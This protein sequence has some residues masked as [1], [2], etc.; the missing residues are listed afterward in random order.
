LSD[1]ASC[2]PPGN[3][4]SARAC[5]P[6]PP[7]RPRLPVW[8]G[9]VGWPEWTRSAS[10][11]QRPQKR[12]KSP[13]HNLTRRARKQGYGPTTDATHQ[14]K[15]CRHTAARHQWPQERR[16]PRAHEIT[17]QKTKRRTRPP[18]PPHGNKEKP[19][20]NGQGKEEPPEAVRHPGVAFTR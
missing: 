20:H 11:P 7:Q 19:R 15:R 5:H 10:A 12:R 6:H 9:G 16:K 14:W 17:Y 8:R 18:E 3:V 2:S 13:G 1:R 4:K